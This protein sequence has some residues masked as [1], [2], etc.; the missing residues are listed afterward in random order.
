MNVNDASIHFGLL[1][2]TLSLVSDALPW[3]CHV[4]SMQLRPLKL[5]CSSTVQPDDSNLNRVTASRY[6]LMLMNCAVGYEMKC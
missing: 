4:I 2:R 3:S 6:W 1:I 5:L